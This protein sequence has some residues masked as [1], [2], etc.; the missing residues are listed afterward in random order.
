ML[1]SPQ[2]TTNAAVDNYFA[3]LRRL[4][5]AEVRHQSTLDDLD[6]A[7]EARIPDRITRAWLAV[8]DSENELKRARGDS[9]EAHQAYW[10]GAWLRWR[11][12]CARWRNFSHRFNRIAYPAGDLQRNPAETKI[13]ACLAEGGADDIAV[14]VPVEEPDCLLLATHEGCHIRR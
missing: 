7:I 13:A 3:A 8:R 5:S 10:R 14:E 9:V 6:Q 11:P 2:K 4:E 1:F 12:R